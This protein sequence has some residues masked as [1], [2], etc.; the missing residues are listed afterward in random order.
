ML[1][2]MG[3]KKAELC[4]F[5]LRGGCKKGKFCLFKHE[6]IDPNSRLNNSYRKQPQRSTVQEQK[7]CK[8]RANCFK[9]PN[10]GFAHKEICRFQENCHNGLSCNFVHFNTTFLGGAHR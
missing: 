8:Y 9:F 4:R 1:I 10:C 3:H 5:N 7:Q 6:P 2:A